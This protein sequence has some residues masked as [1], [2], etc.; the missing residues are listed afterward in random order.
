[1]VTILVSHDRSKVGY[2]NLTDYSTRCRHDRQRN[3][4]RELPTIDWSPFQAPLESSESD[5]LILLETCEAAGSVGFPFGVASFFTVLKMQIREAAS[6]SRP[7]PVVTIYEKIKW[8]T[9]WMDECFARAT[10]D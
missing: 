4:H 2:L 10:Y 6:S 1:M 3:G 9:R 8:K 5:V 7:I